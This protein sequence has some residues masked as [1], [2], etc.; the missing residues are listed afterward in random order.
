M[1]GK[2]KE[3]GWG[4]GER[5]NPEKWENGKI[6]AQKGDLIKSTRLKW[7]LISNNLKLISPMNDLRQNE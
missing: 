5:G 4:R 1:L 3:R 2:S 6:V 7:N